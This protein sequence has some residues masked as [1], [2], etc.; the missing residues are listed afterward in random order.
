MT[1]FSV[2]IVVAVCGALFVLALAFLVLAE[3]HEAGQMLNA[4]RSQSLASKLAWAVI[5]LVP[6]SYT[7][8]C[9]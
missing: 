1:Y 8:R 5:V 9:V 4:F 3:G 2:R 7:H 6:V